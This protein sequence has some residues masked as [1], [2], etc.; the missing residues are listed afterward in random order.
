MPDPTQFMPDPGSQPEVTVLLLTHNPHP[1]RLRRTLASLRH[2][3]LPVRHWEAIVVDNASSPPLHREI[4]PK[5]SPAA[6][7]VV[8]E[9]RLGLSHARRRGIVEARGKLIVMVDDDNVLDPGYLEQA[10]RLATAH[11]R[12]GAFGGRSLP[13][14]EVPPPDWARE[15]FGMLALR[16]LGPQP[17]IAPAESPPHTYPACGPIGAGM[18]LRLEAARTWFSAPDGGFSD[19]RGG[20]LTSGGDNDIVLTVFGAGWD[21]AYFPTLTLTHLIPSGRLE[22]EYLARLNRG[23]Q[24]SWVQVLA[25][26]GVCPWPRITP[27][28]VKFRQLKTWWTLRAWSGAAARIRWQGAC[29]HFEG[30]ALLKP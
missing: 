10:V 28:T 22:S 29:G 13:E 12:T 30:R 16:D 11:P 1:E 27:R 23:I 4:L 26:H 2:Q 14:F 9:P 17:I 7:R 18:V 15:F 3:T 20:E 25:S 21:V 8:V 24:K 6:L 19:R 5:E